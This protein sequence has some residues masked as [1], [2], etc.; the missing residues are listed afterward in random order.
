MKR[1]LKMLVIC[2][3]AALAAASCGPGKEQLIRQEKAERELGKQYML[4]GDFTSALRHLL[5]AE[6][7]Y[8]DDHILQNYIA[9]TYFL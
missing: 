4:A 8:S 6:K 7:L 5:E 2:S 9:Q 1:W 3:L